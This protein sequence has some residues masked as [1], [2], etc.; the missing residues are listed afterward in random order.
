MDV[1]AAYLGSPNSHGLQLLRLNHCGLTARQISRLFRTMGQARRLTAHVSG[2]R[3]DDGIDDLCSAVAC[4]FGPWSLFLQMVEFT[5][6]DDYIKLLRA[7]TVNKTI[8]CL[9][10]AGTATVDSASSVACQAVADFFS[11]NDAV[12]FLDISGYDS[13]LDEGR[14]GREFS[15]ALS[16][17]R[18]NTRIEH[19]RV[20]S[21]MLN[22][23]IGDLAEAISGNKALHTLD[24]EGNDFNLSNFRHLIRHLGENM[25]IR[26]F[27]AFSDQELS[28]AIRKSVQS[29]G[30][31]AP[32]AR[33]SSVIS[34]F[35]T[36]KTQS[37]PVKPLIQQL[38]DE[39]DTAVADLELVLER[40]Q[41]MMVARGGFYE[42]TAAPPSRRHSDV[43]GAF[44]TA[45]G[46]LARREFE[47]QRPKGSQ[48]S[49]S[50][51]RRATSTSTHSTASEFIGQGI[52]RPVSTV[53]SEAPASPTTDG[54]SSGGTPSPPDLESPA[55]AGF[56]LVDV[57]NALATFGAFG[58][59]R[60]GN[61]SGNGG[62]AGGG[63]SNKGSQSNIT[64]YTYSEAQD[65][66][67][68][69]QMK[70]YRRYWGS[71]TARIDEEDGGICDGAD[72]ESA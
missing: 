64:N 34:R 30:T 71:T 72:R 3:L 13:K 51:Q 55:D 63:S 10:L 5:S 19:L 18:S 35:R 47:S 28:R 9:S 39:W 41:Q 60:D 25:T 53:S 29:A 22:I 52:A 70:R 50:Q 1:L 45:F 31:A 23:N 56:S 58:D 61:N 4:G 54:A 33:R 44:S 24:C 49:A 15:K 26:H 7:L 37:V 57:Q 42:E 46:G 20:R 43:E 16:G 32:I 59:E 14:L 48:E 65:A 68:G 38:R 67:G 8:E 62:G 40:N 69:V 17:M 21:Q 12:R 27:S 2:N 11:K 36:D 66:E 6:E